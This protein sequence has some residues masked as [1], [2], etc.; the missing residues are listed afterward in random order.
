[1]AING[2]RKPPFAFLPW[3]IC[4][5]SYG[6]FYILKANWSGQLCLSLYSLM[7]FVLLNR[8]F[9]DTSTT[10]SHQLDFIIKRSNTML[11]EQIHFFLKPVSD[12]RVTKQSPWLWSLSTPPLFLIV[13]I[14]CET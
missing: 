3:L 12:L 4:G 14:V 5:G 2:C 1:M 7:L 13:L 8:R 10:D 11:K 9:N 6:S